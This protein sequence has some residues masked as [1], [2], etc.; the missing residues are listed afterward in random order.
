M[1]VSLLQGILI[2]TVNS[3]TNRQG[4]IPVCMYIKKMNQTYKEEKHGIN[5]YQGNR[6]CQERGTADV[7]LFLCLK[8]YDKATPKIQTF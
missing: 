3:K 6:I 4:E 7:P 1:E 5:N 2:K 8:E